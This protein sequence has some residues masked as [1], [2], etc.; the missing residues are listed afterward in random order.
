MAES[1]KYYFLSTRWSSSQQLA[2]SV[3]NLF[4]ANAVFDPVYV[5]GRSTHLRGD[6]AV[7]IMFVVQFNSKD[8]FEDFR[9]H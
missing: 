7:P 3:F 9:W 1:L 6:L 2:I 4:N 8:I 5:V